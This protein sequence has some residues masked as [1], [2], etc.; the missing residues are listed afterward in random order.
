M[1]DCHSP[2][3]IDYKLRSQ[4]PPLRIPSCDLL[5]IRLHAMTKHDLIGVVVQA[6]N[7]RARCV[8]G[9]HNLHSLYFWS[10]QSKMR[11]FY[12]AADYI[13]ID[14]M[15]LI[16]LGRLCGL[17]FKLMHRTTNLDLLPLLAPEAVRRQWRVFYLGSRPGVAERAAR[18]LRT[19]Y[20]EL[21]IA[22]HDG[23][24]ET[25]QSGEENQR[26]LA[27]IHDYAPDVL[28]VGMGMPRQEIWIEENLK[29]IAATAIFCCG[30]LMDL[31][32]GEIPT[33][34]RWFGSL[35][36]EWLFRLLS[37]PARTWRRYLIEPWVILI[38]KRRLETAW[39]GGRWWLSLGL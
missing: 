22:T 10:H 7:D 8:I 13:Q 30:G 36:F 26:V 9:N 15:P 11:D 32:A 29:D 33:P 14:G 17:P 38:R 31:V 2:D 4:K 16:W 28:M 35:G 5:G 12:S 18:T 27:E 3:S 24:F 39:T 1:N 23:Y 19:Q 6:V 20:P 34:P 21:Q 25:S 37:Q